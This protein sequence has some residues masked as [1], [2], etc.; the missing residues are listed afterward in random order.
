MQQLSGLDNA[1]LAMESTE[2]YGHVGSVCLLDPS[3][4]PQPVD[5]HRLTAL[6]ASRLHLVPLFHRRLLP[7]PFGLDQ[8]YWIEDPDP[9]LD[10]HVRE[11]ALPEPGDDHQLAVQVARLHAVPLDRSR[12]LWE[13]YLITGLRRGRAAVYAKIHHAAMDGAS[14]D[15]VL[16]ALLDMSPQGRT[17]PP[18]PAADGVE[19]PPGTVCMLSRSALS[20]IRQPARVVRVGR[21]LL[22]SSPGLA[23]AAADRLPFLDRCHHRDA[24]A[25]HSGLRAPHV[26]FNATISRHRRWAFADLSMRD[27]KQVKNRAGVTVNDVVMALCAGALRR[28]L[29]AHDALPAD[30]LV[31]AVPVSLRGDDGNGTFGNQLSAMLAAVPTNVG[32]PGERLVAATAAMH[33]AKSEHEAIPPTLLSDA[34]GFALPVLANPAW[35]LSGKLR[36]L[37]LANPYNLFISNVP[38]PRVPLYYA[39]AKLLAYFPISAISHG[40]G[41]NITVMSYC[42]RLCFG[43]LACRKLVPDL[44]QLAAW[45]SQELQLLLAEA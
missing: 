3:T 8:P 26:P 42:D 41:L 9:S 32:T 5:L 35:Q 15:D 22:G 21:G 14:G 33:A 27:V 17:V 16:A 20:L 4:A 11:I 7:V 29:L 18:P 6:I 23:V 10:Y 44:E 36:L 39:G 31:A 38:G 30:P 2:V 40:Q 34:A 28:W 45:L 43:L 12:P 37:E 13:L 25:P 24:A 1:F 19:Q